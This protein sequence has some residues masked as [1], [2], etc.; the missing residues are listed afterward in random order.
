MVSACF[1]CPCRPLLSVC[2]SSSLVQ[3]QLQ[4]WRES[5]YWVCGS[6][7]VENGVQAAAGSCFVPQDC[8]QALCWPCNC[9]LSLS[10]RLELA[11]SCT[12]I[13]KPI[14]Q[15]RQTAGLFALLI[16]P[17]SLTPQL[18]PAPLLLMDGE[19]KLGALERRWRA[20]PT[21]KALHGKIRVVVANALL[22]WQTVTTEV[23]QL[24]LIAVV[25]QGTEMFW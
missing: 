21:W 12:V 9:L 15:R 7:C 10:Q 1:C 16:F 20:P 24:S 25:A 8:L 13:I 19:D 4:L 18:V 11:F 3:P 22:I 17:D 6:S 2:I 5:H 23:W 14:H